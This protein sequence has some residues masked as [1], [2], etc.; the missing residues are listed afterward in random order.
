M[1][2]LM[3]S[4]DARDAARGSHRLAG[5]V[6]LVTGAARGIGAAAARRFVSEGARV[7]VA[8][9]LDDEG[10]VAAAGLGE[11]ALYIHLDVRDQAAWCDAVRA[12]RDRFGSAPTVLVH[13]AGVMVPGT[14]ENADEAAMRFAFEVNV[15]GPALGTSA[16][17]PGMR[18]AGGGVIIFVSSIASMTGGG[19]FLPYASSKAANATYARCAAQELGPLGIRVNSL[20]PGGVETPMNSGPDFAALDREAWF[21]RM[22]IPRIGRPDEVAD[23]LLYLVSD[24]SSYVTG[25]SLIVDGG[26][27]LGPAAAWASPVNAAHQVVPLPGQPRQESSYRKDADRD[28]D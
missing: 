22:A 11:Q 2:E 7:V 27:V 12:A 14:A 9:V 16:C 8:D 21:G 5:R 10:T 19:G 17:V 28:H 6:A 20:H 3:T 1:A 25:T 24:E 4:R 18:A 23:A 13:N 26:Q 15:L